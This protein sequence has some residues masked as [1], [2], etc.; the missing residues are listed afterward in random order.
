V[1]IGKKQYCEE[2]F[3]STTSPAVKLG[4]YI[5]KGSSTEELK[6]ILK[7]L[8]FDE[9]GECILNLSTSPWNEFTCV[10]NSTI[11]AG[12][13]YVCIQAN[14]ETDHKLFMESNQPVCGFY[15]TF[16]ENFTA[17][18]GL[19]IVGAQ[20][21][22]ATT[23][24][25]V[26]NQDENKKLL[27]KINNYLYEKYDNSCPNGCAIPIALRSN[28]DQQ[29]VLS[30]ITVSYESNT[31]THE[32]NTIFDAEK[33]PAKI[34]SEFL[35]LKLEKANFT[36]NK[37]YGR[38]KLRLVLGGENVLERYIT[39]ERLP[40]I[41]SLSP[42][43]VPAGMPVAFT[44]E[45]GSGFNITRYIWDFG[46]NS[47]EETTTNK[48]THTYSSLDTYELTVTVI[49]DNG[50]NASKTFTV[51]S[52]SP[53]EAISITIATK[54]SFLEM[55]KED[56]SKLGWF[57]HYAEDIIG[58]EE[59][60]EELKSIKREFNQLVETVA[61]DSDFISLAERLHAL[62]IPLSF[63]KTMDA[64]IRLQDIL[65]L[66][67]ISP[68]LLSE[69]GAGELEADSQDYK[70]AIV[71]WTQEQA[72]INIAEEIYSLLYPTGETEEKITR[73]RLSLPPLDVNELYIIINAEPDTIHIRNQELRTRDIDDSAFAILLDSENLARAQEIEFIVEGKKELF[74]TPV[75]ISP[76]FDELPLSIVVG[77]CNFNNICE[78]NLGE[79]WRN[80]RNDCK[81]IGRALFMIIV[82]IIFAFIV[83]I[84]MQ[85][86]Y[87][88]YYE[89]H[90]FKDRN[91][92]YNLVT[93]VYR[94]VS[95]GKTDTEIKKIL[96]EYK[97]NNEQ[98][99]YAILS[100]I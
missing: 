9:K 88:K 71:A 4:A 23:G 91:E 48:V 100:S 6:L 61:E 54:D 26:I 43:V 37:S 95:Q 94:M 89:K 80:C 44:I 39:V 20:Y 85:E 16:E 7:N 53:K 98:I 90:L 78:A 69:L 45:L 77:P 35:M 25:I 57:K 19:F 86:W 59:L 27:D 51:I 14:D 5:E 1:I 33:I 3:L 60:D 72:D 10:I 66:E 21:S 41:L 24:K 17:D 63:V 58:I 29:I 92:L 18:Y 40:E 22:G 96:K 68:D 79:N 55:L 76:N 15:E 49:A 47:T 46:D 56:M 28:T 38:Y 65:L 8:D 83:Y 11:P 75:Y 2:V 62:H 99:S 73:F 12:Q 82:V 87:K 84:A 74:E 31:G 42:R 70:K 64:S 81:P 50:K 34:S 32:Q 36:I 52:G 93:F 13:Y 30:D 97:W 67:K